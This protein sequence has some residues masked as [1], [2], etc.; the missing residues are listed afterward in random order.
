MNDYQGMFIQ[1]YFLI[2]PYRML[3]NLVQL[4]F[5]PVP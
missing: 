5:V 3:I 4:Q 2:E 1:K